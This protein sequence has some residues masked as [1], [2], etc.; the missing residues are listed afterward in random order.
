MGDRTAWSAQSLQRG[1]RDLVD[2]VYGGSVVAASLT[3]GLSRS[4]VCTWVSGKHR[5]SL[6]GLM[7]LCHHAGAD[8]LKLLIGRFRRVT[9]TA[10]AV[11]ETTT[12]AVPLPPMPVMPVMPVVLGVPTITFATVLPTESPGLFKDQLEAFIPKDLEVAAYVGSGPRGGGNS[13]VSLGGE[14][15]YPERAQLNLMGRSYNRAPTTAAEQWLALEAALAEVTIP[16][17][18]QLANTLG[19]SS[20]RLRMRWPKQCN[21]LTTASGECRRH[22]ETVK[23]DET[24]AT[25][26]QCATELVASG[27]P[28]TA[29]Y[30]QLASGVV[31]FHQNRSRRMVRD[32]VVVRYAAAQF[33]DL[34]KTGDGPA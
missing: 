15:R 3:A 2:H 23:L 10:K 28:V 33:P 6:A 4:S 32:A 22:A 29:K 19:T 11:L 24:E 5:P 34:A 27:R 25:Y 31:A 26:E 8:A 7:Q 20:R 17:L 9:I 12:P 30:L 14:T 21:A 13:P 18:T 1:L 16:N